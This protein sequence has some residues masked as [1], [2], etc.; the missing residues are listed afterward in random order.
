MPRRSSARRG[1]PCTPWGLRSPVL[2]RIE[3]RLSLLAPRP[4]GLVHLPRR[5][6]IRLGPEHVFENG[7]RILVERGLEQ[8]LGVGG[9]GGR[10]AARSLENRRERP[11]EVAG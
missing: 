5:G 8:A 9:R 6:A 3:A 1:C 11:V 10:R 4:V 2:R 7:S